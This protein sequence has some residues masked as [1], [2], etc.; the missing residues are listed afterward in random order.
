[1]VVVAAMFVAPLG[2]VTP[3]ARAIVQGDAWPNSKFHDPVPAQAQVPLLL[4]ISPDWQL[5]GQLPPHP[6]VPLH[7]PEQLGAHPHTPGVPL[8]PHVFG[9]EQL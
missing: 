2:P 8:P 1:L 7:L 4:Q 6:L 9:D 3:G 5:L